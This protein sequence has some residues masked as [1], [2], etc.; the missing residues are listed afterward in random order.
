MTELCRTVQPRRAG[1]HINLRPSTKRGHRVASGTHPT[2]DGYHAV[3]AERRK[4][5]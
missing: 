4:G 5:P 3:E 2:W 1:T